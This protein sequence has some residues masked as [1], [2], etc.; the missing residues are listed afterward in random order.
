MT[1]LKDKTDCGAALIY[2]SVSSSG[3]SSGEYFAKI[4]S[5]NRETSSMATEG[6]NSTGHQRSR[7]NTA[8]WAVRSTTTTVLGRW[9]MD[10]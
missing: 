6:I 8:V 7:Q 10:S 2:S 4:R 3:A 1:G 9:T 5:V